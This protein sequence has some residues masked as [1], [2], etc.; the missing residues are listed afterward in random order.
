MPEAPTTRPSLLVRLRD[1]RDQA[2][3]GQFVDLYAPLVYG[4][5]RRRGLQDADAADLTQ[6]VLRVVASAVARLVYDPRRG[7]FRGWLFTIVRS[8][9]CNFLRRR[10]P[11]Q[12]TG[13]PAMQ[14]LLA[15]LPAGPEDSSE[16][17]TEYEQRLFAWAVEQVRPR[18][19]KTTWEAFRQTAVEGQSSKQVA[20]TLG[21]RLGAVH[22]ARSRVMAR[23]RAAVQQARDSESFSPPGEPTS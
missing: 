11:C 10:D 23:L 2:A 7:S 4:Y 14:S 6:T 8:K 13:D 21:I 5:A 18:V 19:R 22:L 1:P 15:A 3:W 17:D 12:G 16:W 9:L 20:E